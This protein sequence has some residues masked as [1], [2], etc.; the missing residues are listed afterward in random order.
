VSHW[1]HL[2]KEG[3]AKCVMTYSHDGFGLGHLRRNTTIASRLVSQ[4][5]KS[6]VLMLIGCPA[7]A[8]FKLPTGVDF[9]KLPSI[10]KQDTGVWRPLRLRIGLEKTKALRITTIQQV[11]HV[12]HPHLLLV[13]HV[14]TGV[15][16]ELVSLL[17]MLKQSS[18]PPLIVLGLRNI[19]DRPEVTRALWECEGAYKAIREYYD[20]ILIYGCRDVFDTSSEYGLEREFAPRVRYCG[21]V[22]TEE[23]YKSKEEMRRE[24]EIEH[25]LIVVTGGGGADAYPMM[26][27]CIKAL[28]LLGAHAGVE[29]ILITGPLMDHEQ[30]ERLREHAKT[31]KGRVRVLTQVEDALSYLNAADL[32]VTMAGYNTM[33]Q[34][35]QLRRRALVVPRSGPSAEQ[36]MRA[37]LFADR[38]LVDVAFREELLPRKLAA[39][40]MENLQRK[41]DLPYD[42][43]INT[44]GGKNAAAR[45][46]E[47]LASRT[48]YPVR[49]QIEPQNRLYR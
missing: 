5:P 30:R 33:C 23:P 1:E 36:Q 6:S 40:L 22:C 39:K 44:N 14:P 45:L 43:A 49:S 35:L 37:R 34:V 11:A 17:E 4:V 10:I 28:K 31:Q 16:G 9:I 46:S 2:E 25:P 27:T 32:V 24:L 7:G 3:A 19:L 48:H 15:W 26:L 47:L 41:D 42:P 13:D 12:F 29:A 18:D 20:E 38:G 21:Y 8:V